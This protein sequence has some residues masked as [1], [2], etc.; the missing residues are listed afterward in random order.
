[1][2]E[3]EY[4]VRWLGPTGVLVTQCVNPEWWGK[5]RVQA[6]ANLVGINDCWVTAPHRGRV[7]WLHAPGLVMR[8]EVVAR[9]WGR[10]PTPE[11]DTAPVTDWQP[12]RVYTQPTQWLPVPYALTTETQSKSYRITEPEI[13]YIREQAEK[14]GL[15]LGEMVR[16]IVYNF[17]TRTHEEQA[18]VVRRFQEAMEGVHNG[19]A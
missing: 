13:V 14:W 9:M 1:M 7:E 8:G 19:E 16:A 10:W 12:V 18:E 3:R 2:S 11:Q 17:G 15:D 4:V 6:Y 5:K